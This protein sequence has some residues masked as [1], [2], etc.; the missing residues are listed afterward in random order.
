MEQ[1]G[2]VFES[3]PK[4]STADERWSG[5]ESRRSAGGAGRITKVVVLGNTAVGK[6]SVIRRFAKGEFI[7]KYRATI[8][9]DFLSKAVP[10]TTQKDIRNLPV[11]TSIVLQIWDTAGQERFRALSSVFFRGADACV[12]VCSVDD[13]SSLVTGIADWHAEFSAK[14]QDTFMPCLLL[15][16]TKTDIIS[17]EWQFTKAEVEEVAGTLNIE[18]VIY[19]SSLTGENIEHLFTFVASEVVNRSPPADDQIKSPSQ[20]NRS[21]PAL[22]VSVTPEALQPRILSSHSNQSSRDCLCRPC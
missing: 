6:T 7:E 9:A 19:V 15:A 13:R 10:V 17:A 16:V 4:K 1:T 20:T 2:L 14:Q 3:K 8:G 22:T 11:A 18:T 21:V 12:L 5:V